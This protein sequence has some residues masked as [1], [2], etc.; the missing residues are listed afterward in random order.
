[1]YAFA[2]VERCA[3]ACFEVNGIEVALQRMLLVRGND[4]RLVLLVESQHIEHY[5]RATGDLSGREVRFP[6][7]CGEVEQIEMVVAVALA[8]HDELVAVPRQ[9][10]DGVERFHI[11]ITALSVELGQ[12]LTRCGIIAHQSAVLLVA[13]Q[14]LHID[15]LRVR[16]PRN[17]GEVVEC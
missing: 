13:C 3:L 12:Q 6:L 8:L 2:V 17:V 7:L 4:Y 5:P 9:E 1:M 15:G 14:L 16:T 11:F 10:H